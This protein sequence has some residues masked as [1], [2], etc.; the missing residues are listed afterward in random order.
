MPQ[1]EFDVPDQDTLAERSREEYKNSEV[2]IGI[3]EITKDDEGLEKTREAILL[4]AKELKD[5]RDSEAQEQIDS[6][7]GEA[8]E[9]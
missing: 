6:Q 5:I 9:M 7:E 2:E 4:E 1:E 8:F 3:N